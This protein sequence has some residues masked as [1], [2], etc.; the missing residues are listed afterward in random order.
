MVIKKKWWEYE[1][2]STEAANNKAVPALRGST[3]NQA[4]DFDA[5][6]NDVLQ[7]SQQEKASSDLQISQKHADK[8]KA[9]LMQ[10]KAYRKA[11]QGKKIRSKNPRKGDPNWEGRVEEIDDPAT[12]LGE[13]GMI[14]IPERGIFIPQGHVEPVPSGSRTVDIAAD[15]SGRPDEQRAALKGLKDAME[16]VLGQRENS[17]HPNKGMRQLIIAEL[18]GDEEAY[19]AAFKAAGLGEK[20]DDR[21]RIARLAELYPKTFTRENRGLGSEAIS[22]VSAQ[23]AAPTRSERGLKLSFNRASQLFRPASG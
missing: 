11:V 6:G 19:K 12:Q 10:D 5:E 1:R 4:I 7:F 13:A 9:G 2:Q 22:L 18:G 16:N 15:E 21:A 17:K 23:E 8:V 3:P 20:Y 14:R